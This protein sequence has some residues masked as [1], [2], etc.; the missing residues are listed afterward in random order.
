MFVLNWTLPRVSANWN[1][2][3]SRAWNII[4]LN[5]ARNVWRLLPYPCI[6][7]VKCSQL[8]HCDT[9]SSW[10]TFSHLSSR[11]LAVA[12][13]WQVKAMSDGIMPLSCLKWALLG[14]CGV[15]LVACPS[16]HLASSNKWTC[17]VVSQTIGASS[18]DQAATFQ[19]HRQRPPLA[20]A[21]LPFNQ[22]LPRIER[23]RLCYGATVPLQTTVI[24]IHMF[25]GRLCRPWCVCLHALFCF[26]HLC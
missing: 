20:L 23:R 4:G 15:T 19:G 22:G 18:P 13:K 25:W 12:C 6:S 2:L 11:L 8:C 3:C 10:A 9:R 5:Y 21:P 16:S 17:L 14:R 26:T 24:E 1:L 7:W